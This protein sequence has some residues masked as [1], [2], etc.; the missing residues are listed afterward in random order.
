MTEARDDLPA[1]P[2][3]MLNLMR[4]QRRRTQR[5]ELRL[6]VVMLVAWAVSWG[7]G[8]GALWS[9]ESTG[10]NPW[11]RIPDAV[12]WAVFGGLLVAAIIISI[13]AGVRSGTA[14]RGPSRLAGALYGWSW[15]ISMVAAWGV[16]T[17]VRRAGLSD[18]AMSV[19]APA[20]FILIVGVLY[21]AGGALWRSTVQYALGVVMIVTVV[22]ASFAGAPTHHLIYATVGPA[23]MLTVAVMMARG[24]FTTQEEPR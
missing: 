11:L 21:L 4:D 23:A 16:L 17:A 18:S 1:D 7:I 3:A 6:Y 12:A 22:G 24:V 19:L 8:F 13:V 9:A 10:G 5:W 15:T 2:A 20:L 14:V